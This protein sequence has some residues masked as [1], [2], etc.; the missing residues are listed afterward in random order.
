[1]ETYYLVDFENVHNEGLK[2]INDLKTTDHV[3]IFYTENAP[4][5][6]LD[7][8]LADGVDIIGHN[9]PVRKQSVDMHLVSYL[10]YLLGMDQSKQNAFYIISKDKDYDNIV[11]YWKDTGYSKLY[12]KAALPSGKVVTQQS[13][14]KQ[15]TPNTNQENGRKLSGPEKSRIYEYVQHAMRDINYYPE[16][17]NKVG[18]FVAKV[19]G[20][21]NALSKLHNLI[22]NEYQ[23]DY[24]YNEIYQDAKEIYLDY[25][26]NED[27]NVKSNQKKSSL[28]TLIQGIIAKAGYSSDTVNW[29][30]SIVVNNVNKNNAKQSIHSALVREFGQ[31]QG[32]DFYHR[33]KNYV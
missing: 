2:N 4:S 6:R 15:T 33:V 27:V 19:Y 14:K 17:A 12:R 32:N 16:F 1:M 10:G 5:I 7:I 3:H 18:S 9:V 26:E 24:N 30:A 29:V 8:A 31:A 22:K 25:K 28:N 20:E 21:Q 11:T 23:S 13:N